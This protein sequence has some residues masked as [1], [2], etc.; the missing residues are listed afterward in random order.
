MRCFGQLQDRTTAGDNLEVDLKLADVDGNGIAGDEDFGDA[1]V[2]VT[3][4]AVSGP[5]V[6]LHLVPGSS[7]KTYAGKMERAGLY[8]VQVSVGG[9]MLPNWRLPV[10][11]VPGE[12]NAKH[13]NIR[14][15][16][17]SAAASTAPVLGQPLSC[18]LTT[19]DEHGNVRHTG[20][21]TV[22]PV[23]IR[24]DGEETS[25]AKV[26]D[27]TDG[28][29]LLS[30]TPDQ[31]GEYVVTALVNGEEI[32]ADQELQATVEVPPLTVDMCELFVP[33]QARRVPA[34][35]SFY[36]TVGPPESS[37]SA[38]HDGVRC[39]V[40]LQDPDNA[41][42]LFPAA[43]DQQ[44]VAFVAD[45]FLGMVG[46]N[47]IWATI[48]VRLGVV[49]FMCCSMAS[50]CMF[51]PVAAACLLLVTGSERLAGAMSP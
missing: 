10:S 5:A 23:V 30:F 42:T 47:A 13:C 15:R 39:L 14:A 19:C 22:S 27:L 7:G 17:T 6:P 20:G 8:S 45:V 36:V 35:S 34:G 43:W 32:P 16:P 29:Y 44:Q 46:G 38:P 11:V 49:C 40:H 50:S 31:P 48:D 51:R 28:R 3:A 12:A 24:P 9:S 2:N 25:K 33:D 1:V 41:I 26:K 4:I 21:A 37:E 18:I